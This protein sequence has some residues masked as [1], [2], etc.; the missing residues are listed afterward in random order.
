MEPFYNPSGA[1]AKPNLNVLFE[2]TNLALL[3]MGGLLTVAAE[4]LMRNMAVRDASIRNIVERDR[5]SSAKNQPMVLQAFVVAVMQ[6][7]GMVFSTVPFYNFIYSSQARHY[8]PLTMGELSLYFV[9]GL[10]GFFVAAFVTIRGET[11]IRGMGASSIHTAG[12]IVG[13]IGSFGLAYAVKPML[14]A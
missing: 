4:T 2:P 1:H 8:Q 3:F 7:F 6:L 14:S 9:L 12:Y 5:K 10:L 13:A 11:K